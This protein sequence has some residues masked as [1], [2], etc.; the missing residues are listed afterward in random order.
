MTANENHTFA[1][2]RNCFGIPDTHN[3]WVIT[4]GPDDRFY[5]SM[6]HSSDTWE[7]LEDVLNGLEQSA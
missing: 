4:Q 6:E 1:P 2:I 7:E 3:G 5:A